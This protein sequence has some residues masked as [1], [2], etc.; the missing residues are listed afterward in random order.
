MLKGKSLCIANDFMTK[1]QERACQASSSVVYALPSAYGDLQQWRGLVDQ[2][3][4]KADCL[5]PG[6]ACRVSDSRVAAAMRTEQL[7]LL[8]MGKSGVVQTVVGFYYPNGSGVLLLV[9]DQQP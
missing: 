7:G 8:M 4:Q 5:C 1:A 9:A 3:L 6:A 2:Q